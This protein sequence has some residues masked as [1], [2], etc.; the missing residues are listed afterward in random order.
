MVRSVTQ[1]VLLFAVLTGN[2]LRA[3]ERPPGT[4]Q[5]GGSTMKHA[6]GSFEIKMMPVDVSEAGKAGGIG[7][8]T[9]EKTF[10]G[11]LE[12]TSQGEM[13]TGITPFSGSMAYVAIETVRGTVNGHRG[14]FVLSHNAT[15]M[16]GDPA[17]A[18]ANIVVVPGS[19]TAELTGLSGSL[20]IAET[21]G[22]HTYDFTYALPER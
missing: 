19:G 2:V 1:S 15:M 20:A 21:G 12:G 8:M 14:T 5:K 10:H 16:K 11:G 6:S 7:R 22:Q 17:S 18:V 13:L 3:Q 9:I 4:T